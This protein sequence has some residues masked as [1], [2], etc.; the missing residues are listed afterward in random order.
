MYPLHRLRLREDRSASG[1]EPYVVALE[2][3]S[4]TTALH[5]PSSFLEASFMQSASV[6]QP[7]SVCWELRVWGQVGPGPLT[8]EQRQAEQ[9]PGGPI[10]EG[11]PSTTKVLKSLEVL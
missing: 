6:F 8:Q 3:V 10:E 7:S 4:P 2:S 11:V 5:G 9:V 1:P